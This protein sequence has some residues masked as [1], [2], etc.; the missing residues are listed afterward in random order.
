MSL[1]Q[2]HRDAV[3]DSVN[4][5]RAFEEH[6][7]PEIENTDLHPSNS[8]SS[9]N[10]QK[11]ASFQPRLSDAMQDPVTKD[12]SGEEVAINEYSD[13][14]PNDDTDLREHNNELPKKSSNM[15]M[16]NNWPKFNT[17]RIDQDLTLQ[18]TYHE[19]V[20]AADAKVRG[21]PAGR[22]FRFNSHWEVHDLREQLSQSKKEK[23]T[24]LA[25]KDKEIERLQTRN[26][27]LDSEISRSTVKNGCDWQANREAARK[28]LDRAKQ[29]VDR[30]A[31]TLREENKNLES[32]IE[33]A[34]SRAS[35]ADGR[36]QGLQDQLRA[37][38]RHADKWE[39]LYLKAQ[40]DARN[41]ILSAYEVTPV[42]VPEEDQQTTTKPSQEKELCL[43]VEELQKENG[44]LKEKTGLDGRSLEVDTVPG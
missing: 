21:L 28:C 39:N 32:K 19:E 33:K 5:I 37:T 26:D 35:D 41:Q 3:I 43:L 24:E 27:G 29:A 40:E 11:A 4:P 13:Q 25:A 34:E 9:M 14:K 18:T 7:I 16:E 1:P 6:D 8:L 30:E 20:S 15:L 17:Q 42:Q 36:A 10:T 12:A 38:Q 23:A 22:T 31:K 2:Y 44:E